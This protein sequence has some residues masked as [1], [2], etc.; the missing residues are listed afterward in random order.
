[1]EELIKK[2]FEGVDVIGPYVQEGHYDL[3]GPNGEVIL[4]AVWE[5]VVE[6]DWSITMKMRPLDQVMPRR[7]VPP[8]VPPA[9]VPGPHP[10]AM[11]PQP[12]QRPHAGMAAPFMRPPS[13]QPGG[14]GMAPPPPPPPP[15]PGTPW[16][17]VTSVRPAPH[18]R[19][20]V[21][22]HILT[23]DPPKASRKKE[24]AAPPSVIGWMA[25]KPNKSNSKKYVGP[26]PSESLVH[27]CAPAVR[28]AV[29]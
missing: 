5:K 3:I 22:P 17:G 12:G 26:A 15:P 28:S 1:M 8:G 27:P 11:P 21:E 20:G 13:A 24:R 23:A 19:N 14:G 7:P 6:P 9:G 2:A 10:H 4:P 29:V 16:P 25:G 18:V